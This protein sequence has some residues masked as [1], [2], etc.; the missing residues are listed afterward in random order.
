M[1]L[2]RRVQL[3]MWT[4]DSESESDTVFDIQE[5]DADALTTNGGKVSAIGRR[6]IDAIQG[7]LPEEVERVEVRVIPEGQ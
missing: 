5:Y 3:I 7:H 2:P 4:H 6:I 1:N